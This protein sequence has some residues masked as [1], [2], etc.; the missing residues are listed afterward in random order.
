MTVVLSA[1]V[2]DDLGAWVKD[3]A[4][5]RGVTVQTLMAEA[6]RNMRRDCESGVPDLPVV[7][8]P[9]VRSVRA[10]A[11][12]ASRAQRAA[13]EVQSDWLSSRQHRL[14]VAKYGKKA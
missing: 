12:A 11:S 2:D 14:N 1:R 10:G 5:T 4:K 6:V 13:A 8:T 9:K 3:Y 7:D